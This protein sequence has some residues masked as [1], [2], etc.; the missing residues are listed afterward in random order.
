MEKY[1]SLK[2]G[3]SG[4][5]FE[6]WKG[7]VYPKHLKKEEWLNYYE[8]EL[9]FNALEVNYTYYTLPSS[10]SLGGM[11]R[12]TSPDFQFV[13]KAFRGMTHEIKRPGTSTFIDNKDVFKSF[14]SALDPLI[15]A[16]KLG[17]VLAQFPYSFYPRP[18]NL[19]YL[20]FFKEEMGTIPLTVEF[21]NRKWLTRKTLQF[22]EDHCMGYCIVD[23]PKLHSLVP[24]HPDATS[25]IGYFRFHGRNKNWFNVPTSVRYDYLYSPDELCE[26]KDPIIQI[27]EKTQKVFIFF[28][29]CHAGSAAQNARML[30]ELL[31]HTPKP[32][33]PSR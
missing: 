27:A 20:E 2:I 5:S 4:F 23:E 10:R 13:I 14:L 24:F 19:E 17:C 28:N 3:T 6:D 18:S 8:K 11:D 29:N 32:R 31:D 16:G 9:G 30:M 15:H 12:K 26:F 33:A 7:S 1:P 25:P 21:R 22:L